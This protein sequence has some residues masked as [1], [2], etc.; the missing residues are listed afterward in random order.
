[1]KFEKLDNVREFEDDARGTLRRVVDTVKSFEFGMVAMAILLGVLRFAGKPAQADVAQAYGSTETYNERVENLTGKFGNIY[2]NFVN[3]VATSM[4]SERTGEESP[5]EVITDKALMGSDGILT[6]DALRR[7]CESFPENWV[8]GE[9]ESIGF[10]NEYEEMDAQHYGNNFGEWTTLAYC[11]GGF[12]EDKSKIVFLRPVRECELNEIEGAL[13]HELGHANDWW[14]DAGLAWNERVD[15]LWE[16]SERVGA[17]DRY[18][19]AYVEAIELEDKNE[20]RY[21]KTSEYWAE[22][23]GAFYL[24]PQEFA[25]SHP[26]DFELV[27]KY[28]KKGDKDFD[29][30]KMTE[31]RDEAMA[32]ALR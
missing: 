28:Q 6:P 10:K 21:Q 24:N 30:D 23:C 3:D 9:V 4:P 12:V 14:R 13:A 16:I 15:F 31:K 26:K 27:Y 19:S 8:L 5:Q 25:L 17:E 20:E 22:I 11:E 29:V 2:E 32:L 7:L 1:M 18:K